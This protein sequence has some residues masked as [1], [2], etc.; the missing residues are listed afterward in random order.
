MKKGEGLLDGDAMVEIEDDPI[1]FEEAI[2]SI[3]L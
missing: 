1:T 2:K 3:I